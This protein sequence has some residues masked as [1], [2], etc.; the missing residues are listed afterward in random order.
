MW[1]GFFYVCERGKRNPSKTLYRGWALH[2]R[3]P[4]QR[5]PSL[6]WLLN[7]H[8]SP[9]MFQMLSYMLSICR[10]EMGVWEEWSEKSVIPEGSPFLSPGPT[11]S[12]AFLHP[13]QTVPCDL[14][15]SWGLSSL[16][17]CCHWSHQ[18][19]QESFWLKKEQ[20]RKLLLKCDFKIKDKTLDPI[21]LQ[22]L[23]CTVL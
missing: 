13:G 1:G 12:W 2:P 23:P 17:G 4:P 15:R 10:E 21:L 8:T 22:W 19:A 7:M 16:G 9:F 11:S 5:Q 20:K 18:T 3:Q 14:G 6:S